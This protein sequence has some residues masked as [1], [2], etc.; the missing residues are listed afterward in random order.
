MTCLRKFYKAGLSGAD[1]PFCKVPVRC[2]TTKVVCQIVTRLRR[3]RGIQPPARKTD[4]QLYLESALWK[5]IRQRVLDRDGN[6]CKRCGKGAQVVH[7][8]SYDREVLDGFR[9]EALVSLCKRCHEEIE[10]TF[11]K[12]G[13]RAKNSLRQANAKLR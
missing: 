1:C 10:F 12:N 5:T 6:T 9:D 4:Y 13:G 8:K 3:M 11:D 2:N 7:H